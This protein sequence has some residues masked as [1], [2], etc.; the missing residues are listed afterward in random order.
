MIFTKLRD[1]E[2]FQ[3]H[4][5][6]IYTKFARMP[7]KELSEIISKCYFHLCPSEYE[8]FGHGIWEAKSTGGIVI[9]TNAPPMNETV[10]EGVDGFLVKPTSYKR[11]N[12]AKTAI[13]A[14]RDLQA[15]I[16]KTFDLTEAELKGM[17]AAS[18]RRWEENDKYFKTMLIRIINEIA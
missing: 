2:R 15:V 5:E 8:G 9:T 12:I 10:T 11:M 13:I 18:R 7:D 17:S 14:Y 1:Y 4:H 3:A 16:E 6:N